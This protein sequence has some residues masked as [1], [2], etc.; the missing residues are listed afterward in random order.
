MTVEFAAVISLDREHRQLKLSASIG[1]EVAQD[2]ENFRLL[3]EGKCPDV[4]CVI[5]ENY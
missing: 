1:V 4:A 3:F 2:W 5:M